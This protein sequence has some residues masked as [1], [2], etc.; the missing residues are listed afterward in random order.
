MVYQPE[1][2]FAFVIGKT[3]KDV[4]EK[5]ALD[6]VFGYVP[7]FDISTRG[8]VRR[9]QFVGKGQAL[10]AAAVHGSSPKTR[11]PIRIMSM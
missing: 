7:M 3:A 4:P 2:E 9:T 5:K 10:T 8:M 11:F 6:Y 1:A